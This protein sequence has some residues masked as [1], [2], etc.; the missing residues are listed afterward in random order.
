MSTTPPPRFVPVL[1]EVVQPVPGAD[2]QAVER[3][4]Q[5]G[6]D[7]R[8]EIVRRVAQGVLAEIEPLLREA[9]EQL[10]AQQARTLDS[11]R[12]DITAR[13]ARRVDDALREIPPG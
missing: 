2:P 4:P 7:P 12:A 8:D 11:L 1:T 5:A 13:V 3:L 10:S 9:L 6:V